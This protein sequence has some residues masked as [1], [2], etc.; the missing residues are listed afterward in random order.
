MEAFETAK[1]IGFARLHEKQGI[2]TLGERSLHVI[3]KHYIDPDESHHEKSVGVGRIV[4]DIFDGQQ[5]Y[6]IQTRAFNTL[7]PKLERILEHYPV[8]VVYPIA[9]KKR[10]IWVDPETGETTKPRRSPKT[11]SVWDAFKELYKVKMFLTDQ[12]LKIKLVLLDIDEYRLQNGWSK[13]RKKGS[14]RMER[15][16]VDLCEIVELS[17]PEDY[18]SLLPALLPSKFTSADLAQ[19]IKVT[20]SKA[21]TICNILYTIGAIIRVG[22][23]GNAYLYKKTY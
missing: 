9:R 16:P 10:I 19:I 11:G 1:K 13:D 14:H 7:R 18:C 23:Q 12:Q 20:K 3:L 17:K 5:V 8:T 22:K 15:I 2:G 4:A 6:E 21:S